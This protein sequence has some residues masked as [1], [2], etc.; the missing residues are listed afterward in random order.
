[1]TLT[2]VVLTRSAV[3]DISKQLCQ[4]GHWSK[5]AATGAASLDLNSVVGKVTWPMNVFGQTK[6]EA[7]A[8]FCGS[9]YSE[10]RVIYSSGY[11][12]Q[13]RDP[14]CSSWGPWTNMCSGSGLLDGATCLNGS[15]AITVTQIGIFYIT[16]GASTTMTGIAPWQ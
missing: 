16:Y 5:Q 8:L 12:L 13:S 3:P 2:K 4:S 9:S 7:N 15:I 14:G 11:Y 1:M 10:Y 6:T